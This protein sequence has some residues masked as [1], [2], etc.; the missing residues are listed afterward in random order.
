MAP[1]D[2]NVHPFFDSNTEHTNP[3]EP[4]SEDELE[5]SQDR[6]ALD[7]TAEKQPAK[8]KRKVIESNA[9]KNAMR[10]FLGIPKPQPV[11]EQSACQ[12]K[13]KKPR[14]RPRKQV[15]LSLDEPGIADKERPPPDMVDAHD[16]KRDQMNPLVTAL[17]P[18]PSIPS[19]TVESVLEMPQGEPKQL[20]KL[21][22]LGGFGL[23]TQPKQ[24]E[25]IAES[26]HALE[27]P[28]RSRKRK[29]AV[30]LRYGKKVLSDRIRI[31]KQINH[32]MAQPQ[33]EI[34]KVTV[35]LEPKPSPRKTRAKADKA[36]HPFFTGKARKERAATPP[37]KDTHGMPSSF[38]SYTTPGKL[39]SQMHAAQAASSSAPIKVIIPSR[40][41]SLPGTYHAAWPSGQDMHVRGEVD[42]RPDVKPQS[43]RGARKRKNKT[44]VISS[45]LASI[46]NYIPMQHKW[47]RP[48]KLLLSGLGLQQKVSGQLNSENLDHP[49]VRRL[50]KTLATSL[51]PFDVGAFENQ[52]WT[53]KYAPKSAAEVLQAG[54]EAFELK[55]WLEGQT[56]AHARVQKMRT[57]DEEKER[58]KKK[59]KLK[60]EGLDGF[61][62][63]SDEDPQSGPSIPNTI[64]LA[65]PTGCGKTAAV[66]AVAKELGF[67]V[68]EIGPNSRRSGKDILDKVGD[69]S[70]NHQVRR[71]ERAPSVTNSVDGNASELDFTLPTEPD[72]AQSTLT[73]F[74]GGGIKKSKKEPL[75]TKPT[76]KQ[77][78]QTNQLK[79]LK[80][81]ASSQKQSLILIEEADILFE[82]DK[83]FWETI[84]TLSIQSKRPIVL[85]CND[86]SVV[87]LNELSLHT[88]L[89]FRHAPQDVI[90]DYLLLMAAA[91][92]HLI[93]RRDIES[94][95]SIRDLRG[96]LSDL[97]FWCQMAVGD[98]KGGI[99]W[100]LQRWPAGIDKDVEGQTMR[101][102]SSGTYHSALSGIN[103]GLDQEE[104]LIVSWQDSWRDPTEGVFNLMGECLSKSGQGLGTQA[105]REMLGKY[106]KC[107][108]HLSAVDISGQY[109]IPGSEK[110]DLTL[111]PT[112]NKV[113][114]DYVAGYRYLRKAQPAIDYEQFDAHLVARTSLQLVQMLAP[115]QSKL[116]N[117]HFTDLDQLEPPH[118]TRM[119]HPNV[120]AIRRTLNAAFEPLAAYS[121][122]GL[123]DRDLASTILDVAPYVRSIAAYDLALEQQRN[124]LSASI[125]SASQGSTSGGEGNSQ[126]D[127]KRARTTRA[128]RSALEGNARAFT[129]RERWFS[130]LKEEQDLERVMR[131][132]L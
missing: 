36:S 120:S 88:I 45:G 54:Q 64:L 53:Q 14:G 11:E 132:A 100:Y 69:M 47:V 72:A 124:S 38:R 123:A 70:L 62:V 81:K 109:D 71:A 61:V 119:P 128:S 32:I 52:A 44:E 24:A 95:Y 7:G 77:E 60:Q 118:T 130:A 56:T 85:T 49:A 59:R 20:L 107:F 5:I 103:E 111:P 15:R 76:K 93:K 129:R 113:A 43:T 127:V 97:Q 13:E 116:P 18:I 91:E 96:A 90:T 35:E 82:E 37:P 84:I 80:E 57:K 104:Q 63:D 25:A 112:T 16:E 114:L 126:K 29:R 31:G 51:T 34:P 12:A 65:G 89:H 74:F 131:T 40:I 26:E 83:Q 68:F 46:H 21:D 98:P 1:Q 30:L 27:R 67:D 55:Q 87:P 102:L 105:K 2:Q 6:L 117:Q 50:H 39:R 10:D 101:T 48:E 8:R 94:L 9:S 58:R 66:Y 73:A 28:K 115:F 22:G 42:T 17:P 79:I 106:G 41:F 122:F 75:E 108:D 110:L 121:S 78:E 86:E 99:D 125:P 33:P 19:A 4:L 23:L 3:K 92:G